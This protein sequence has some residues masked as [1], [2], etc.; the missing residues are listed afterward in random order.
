MS[1]TEDWDL[2]I[3]EVWNPGEGFG[4]KEGEDGLTKEV[5]NR[6]GEKEGEDQV[7]AG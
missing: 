5:E 7:C 2:S 4:S 1:V 3:L 6:E